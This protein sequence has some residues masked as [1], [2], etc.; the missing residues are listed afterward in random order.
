MIQKV[1]CSRIME[2]YMKANGKMTK[3]MAKV[4][5]S[6]L[7]YDLFILTLYFDDSLGKWFENNGD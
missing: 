7:L 6:D 5:K 3:S 2:T 4:R 1:S